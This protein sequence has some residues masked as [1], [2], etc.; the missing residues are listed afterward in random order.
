MRS[1]ECQKRPSFKCAGYMRL[2]SRLF[3]QL[4]CFSTIS[5]V[6][7]FMTPADYAE[8]HRFPKTTPKP[9]AEFPRW[10]RDITKLKSWPGE[11]PPYIE[12]AKVDLSGIP[13]G[14]QYK[15]GNACDYGSNIC[16]FNCDDCLGPNDIMHCGELV[17]SFDDGPNEETTQLISYFN[18]AQKKVSF[19][20]VGLQVLAYPDIFQSEYLSG[21]FVA[22]H[23]YSHVYLPSLTNRKIAAQFQWSIWA[24]NATANVIPRYFRPPYGGLDN[25]VR[26][27]A[28]KFGLTPIVWDL[29]TDDWC[30]I[31]N[32][33]TADEV[34]AD[35]KQWVE[36]NQTGIILEHDLTQE[37]VTVGIEISKILG[38]RNRTVTA[39]CKIPGA[40]WYA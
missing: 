4:V 22:S 1:S 39:D 27:I 28:A 11:Y 3:L 34:Y 10:L 40:P 6:S 31:T 19:F 18:Q 26:A 9:R 25:R 32:S 38:N 8:L 12:S 16:S 13:I 23:S 33:R 21:H 14:P 5:I 20:V 15:L 24:M 29:D 37:T 7:S 2:F 36:D 30:M 35:V 17:Q